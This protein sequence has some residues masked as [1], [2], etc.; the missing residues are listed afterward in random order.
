MEQENKDIKIPANIWE[1]FTKEIEI[2]GKKK[3][4]TDFKSMILEQQYHILCLEE[5]IK[6]LNEAMTYI[7][8]WMDSEDKKDKIELIKP[9]II[10]PE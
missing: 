10:L 7:A 1:R 3:S 9:S 8:H 5:Q 4:A 2:D 6:K